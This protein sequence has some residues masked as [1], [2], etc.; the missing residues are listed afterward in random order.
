MYERIGDLIIDQ[1]LSEIN[2]ISR[3]ILVI[4]VIRLWAIPYCFINSS[5]SKN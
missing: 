3:V 1:I 2:S 4:I 5:E